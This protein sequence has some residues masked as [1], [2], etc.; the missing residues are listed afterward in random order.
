[1]AVLYSPKIIT[2][3]LV[4]VLDAG[5]PKSYSGSGT[6][7]NDLSGNSNNGTLSN[8]AIFNN[9]NNGA[10]SF[11]GVN[12][13]INTSFIYER[14][15]SFTLNVWTIRRS[16][17]NFQVLIGGVIGNNLSMGIRIDNSNLLFHTYDTQD[18]TLLNVSNVLPLNNWVNISATVVYNEQPSSSTSGTVRLF[19][20]GDNVGNNAFNGVGTFNRSVIIGNPTNNTLNRGYL[21]D[22]SQIQIYNKSLTPEE[23]NQNYNSTKHRYGL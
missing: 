15:S 18:K 14:F 21:G 1:M 16:T 22:I 8:G 12:S 5:N 4:F 23:I 10:I 11:D 13:R 17:K 7:W 19:V 9:I 20:N 6:V 3:G 2:D